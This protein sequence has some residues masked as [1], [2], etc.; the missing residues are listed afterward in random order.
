MRHHHQTQPHP[1]ASRLATLLLLSL[2]V[3]PRIQGESRFYQGT[4][5]TIYRIGISFIVDGLVW[6]AL[7]RVVSSGQLTRRC[8]AGSNEVVAARALLYFAFVRKRVQSAISHSVSRSV[9]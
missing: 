8:S 4:L 5:K 7:G 2:I 6:L 9:C 3:L 1:Q